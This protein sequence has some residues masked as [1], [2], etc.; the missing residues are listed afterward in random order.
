MV[1]L[2]VC[3]W[4]VAFGRLCLPVRLRV[5]VHRTYADRARTSCPCVACCPEWPDHVELV[6]EPTI[7]KT[8]HALLKVDLYDGQDTD[9]RWS[10]MPVTVIGGDGLPTPARGHLPTA[11]VSLWLV[12]GVW[13]GTESRLAACVSTATCGTG[14]TWR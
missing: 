13:S 8:K 5:P 3:R 2:Y 11:S 1:A 4:M 7:A 14:G 9:C 10:G 6:V 12:G